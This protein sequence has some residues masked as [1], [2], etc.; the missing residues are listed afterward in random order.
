MSYFPPEW[1]PT[2]EGAAFLVIVGYGL[3]FYTIIAE[4]RRAKKS[5]PSKPGI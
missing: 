2:M 5:G 1:V 3:L 4:R